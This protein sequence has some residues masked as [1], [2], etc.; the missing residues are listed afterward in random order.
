MSVEQPRARTSD[1][2]RLLG[3]LRAGDSSAVERLFP[4][5]YDELKRIARLQRR[6]WIDAETLNTTA[7]VHEAYM[8][9]AGGRERDW[10]DRAHFLAVAATAMRSILVDHARRRARTKRG[11]GR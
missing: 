2:D 9:L 5:V 8:K 11:S 3:E 6:T 10:R 4:L 7:L 1:V